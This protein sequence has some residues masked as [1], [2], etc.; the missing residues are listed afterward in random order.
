MGDFW[1]IP[2]IYTKIQQESKLLDWLFC[3]LACYLSVTFD[4]IY[5]SNS[6]KEFKQSHPDYLAWWCF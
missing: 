1:K 5:L 2:F 4:L 3:L 6:I